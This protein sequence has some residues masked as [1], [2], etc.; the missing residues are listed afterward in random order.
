M[1]PKHS[2]TKI[3]T[4]SP[5]QNAF[6]N[7][8]LHM[9]PPGACFCAT[10]V[11]VT[12]RSQ[13]M[14]VTTSRP[15]FFAYLDPRGKLCVEASTV[16]NTRPKPESLKEGSDW[17]LVEAA[18][19]FG[20]VQLFRRRY[21]T[22]TNVGSV[23]CQ[24]VI[25]PFEVGTAEVPSARWR[26]SLTN[27]R[28]SFDIDFMLSGYALF[29]GRL[30]NDKSRVRIVGYMTPFLERLSI[31]A[32]DSD[33][34]LLHDDD[35]GD[36]GSWGPETMPTFEDWWKADA[37]GEGLT[38][39]P[40]L[41]GL[42]FKP[43]AGIRAYSHSTWHIVPQTS[44]PAPGR[45]GVMD[46]EG[47]SVGSP[48][49]LVVDD[50]S[51]EAPPAPEAMPAHPLPA[52]PARPAAVSAEDDYPVLRSWRTRDEIMAE[53][54]PPLDRT[55]SLNQCRLVMTYRSCYSC[56]K[57]YE[58]ENSGLLLTKCL[59]R[60]RRF[61]CFPC[62]RRWM[63]KFRPVA[64]ANK[65]RENLGAHLSFDP[66]PNVMPSVDKAA[67][68]SFLLSLKDEQHRALADLFVDRSHGRK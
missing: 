54:G 43:Q 13:R 10:S 21:V 32:Y 53:W 23:L 28:F 58:P 9:T 46:V 25:K 55:A 14:S 62:A 51:E 11:V 29:L 8:Y 31:L 33:V 57:L 15:S 19:G 2:T 17:F 16:E 24:E 47:H 49:L 56:G 12:Y 6:S 30:E 66:I 50:P 37:D 45:E 4:S 35:L 26:G 27:K 42:S 5:L 7:L 52:I 61:T 60:E 22:P 63:S 34:S 20:C 18:Y 68:R 44:A 48:D 3:N 64:N 1:P 67:L 36:G 40:H 38:L 39:K 41:L 65:N 59:I